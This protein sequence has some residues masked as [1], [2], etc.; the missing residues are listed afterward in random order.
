MPKQVTSVNK[1]GT[2]TRALFLCSFASIAMVLTGTFDTLIAIGSILFVAVYMSG[3]FSLL[4]LRRREPD[5]PRPYKAW[6]YPWST[7]AVLVASAGFLA[8]SIVE[9]PKHSLVAV[10]LIVASYIASIFLVRKK[11]HAVD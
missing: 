5:L 9:D 3:F 4:V 10:I 2:P 11:A 7:V 1:G 6:W 8:G